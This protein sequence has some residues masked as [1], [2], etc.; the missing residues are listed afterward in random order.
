MTQL[1][2]RMF[3]HL[4]VKINAAARAA[5]SKIFSVRMS[6]VWGQKVF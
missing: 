4:T 6:G 1:G 2:I 5:G 3:R